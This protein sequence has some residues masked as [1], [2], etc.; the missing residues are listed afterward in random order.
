VPVQFTVAEDGVSPPEVAVPAFL[1]LELIVV[2]D[3]AEP[4]VATLEGAEPLPVGPR[5]TGR[6]RLEGRREGRYPVTFEPGGTATLVTGV[7][8]GP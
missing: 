3:R 1:A 2:N 8:A 4:V 7:E 5:Q 6:V